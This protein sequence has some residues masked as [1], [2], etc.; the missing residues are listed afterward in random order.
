[1]KKLLTLLILS[2]TVLAGCQQAP[3]VSE[4]VD[5]KEDVVKGSQSFSVVLPQEPSKI[6]GIR[7][8]QT[9]SYLDLNRM[10]QGLLELASEKVSNK[11][12]Y[13]HGQ[14]LSEEE[15][16]SLVSRKMNEDQYN[17]ELETNEETLNLGLNPVLEDGQDPKDSKLYISNLIEHDFVQK[18]SD[19]YIVDT[20]AIGVGIDPTYIYD[21]NKDPINISDKE[22]MEYVFKDNAKKLYAFLSQK[23]ELKN[24]NILIG[25]YK[26]SDSYNKPG[27]YMAYS[28]FPSGNDK[29]NLKEYTN[30]Y[31]EF[32]SSEGE[33]KNQAL[34]YSIEK[35]NS[36]L[37]DYYNDFAGISAYGHYIDNNLQEVNIKIITNLY[38]SIDAFGFTSFVEQQV[39][40]LI[41]V[42]ADIRVETSLTDG[43]PVSLIYIEK[44]GKKHTYTYY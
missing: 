14:V 8:S 39:S 23:E 24:S 22:L 17:K 15:A 40:D 18:K 25:F 5:V 28:Y 3:P 7:N 26:Q 2:I 12:L 1:M 35:L 29:V 9:N 34:S 43:S 41:K 30:E 13:R 19:G 32:P 27:K 38:S 6:R 37:F 44:G 11:L 21:K 16:T 20:I 42:S 10:D 36:V 33:E 31:I 4:S